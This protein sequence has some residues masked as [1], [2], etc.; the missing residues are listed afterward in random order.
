MRAGSPLL[1]RCHAEARTNLGYAA[2]VGS[3]GR[4]PDYVAAERWIRLGAV[5]GSLRARFLLGFLYE[6]GLG[7]RAARSNSGRWYMDAARRGHDVAQFKMGQFMEEEARRDVIK[8]IEYLEKA[9]RWYRLSHV[10][11]FEPAAPEITRLEKVLAASESEGKPERVPEPDPVARPEPNGVAEAESA[12]AVR[13]P[14]A[15]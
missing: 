13:G 15:E 8:R 2:L 9:L 11:G 6:Y 14:A 7:V 10:Q 3:E 12:G 5:S 1:L 4:E